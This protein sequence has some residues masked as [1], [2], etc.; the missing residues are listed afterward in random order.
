MRVLSSL[1]IAFTCFSSI[2]LPQ[3]E[4]SKDNMRYM[5]C[6]F[7]LVGVVVGLC[8]WLWTQLCQVL[9]FGPAGLGVGLAL[10][11]VVVSGGIHMDGFADVVDAQA[12]HAEPER[13]RQILKDPHAGAFAAIGVACYL[14]AYFAF[15]C[16][17]DPRF[18]LPLACAPVLSRSLSGIATVVF[19][20][21]SGKGSMFADEHTSANRSVVAVLVVVAFG[22]ACAMVALGG[23]VGAVAVAAALASWGFIYVFSKSQFGGMNGDLAGFFLQIAE[24]AMLVA[25]VFAG[26]V[27]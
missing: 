7:P 10:L 22:V 12:S 9:G 1:V 16:E 6:F 15:A 5:M 26:K 24:L 21:S 25:I 27:V 19:P 14:V 4:W 23:V 8:L 11:P 3:V 18:I 2:P 20:L 17:F 13:K